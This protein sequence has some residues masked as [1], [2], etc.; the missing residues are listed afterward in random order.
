MSGL[1][2]FLY[3][4]LQDTTE[5]DMSKLKITEAYNHWLL[6]LELSANYYFT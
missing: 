6:E 3:I 5:K 2:V 1:C 4:L